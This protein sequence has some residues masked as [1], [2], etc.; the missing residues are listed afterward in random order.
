MLNGLTLVNLTVTARSHL[1][2]R[3]L[4]ENLTPVRGRTGA[5]LQAPKGVVLCH[6]RRRD[7]VRALDRGNLVFNLFIVNHFST[8]ATSFTVHF[9]PRAYPTTQLCMLSI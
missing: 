2:L 6:C 8:S 3:D 1:L 9:I 5:L 7:P 4:S